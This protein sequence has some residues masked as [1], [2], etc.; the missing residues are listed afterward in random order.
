VVAV[1]FVVIAVHSIVETLDPA[2]VQAAESLGASPAV[3]F[4]R[5]VFPLIL[6]GIAS[7]AIFA[8]ATSLDETVIAMFLTGPGQRTLPVQM[9]NGLREEVNPTIT[10]ASTILVLVGTTLLVMVGLLQRRAE[11][12]RDRAANKP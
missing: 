3:A 12:N 10:A 2:L 9:F 1:P 6:P 8:F 4:R 11:M 7:G 5:I